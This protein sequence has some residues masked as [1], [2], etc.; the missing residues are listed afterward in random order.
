MHDG[1]ASGETRELLESVS[2]CANLRKR[3]GA[4]QQ[5]KLGIMAHTAE[6]E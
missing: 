3:H 6:H 4:V 2:R 5:P 1:V